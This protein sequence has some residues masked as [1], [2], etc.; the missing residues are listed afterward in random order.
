MRPIAL[1]CGAVALALAAGQAWAQDACKNR[2]ELDELSD[3]TEQKALI[4]DVL[5]GA[6]VVG[7]AVTVVLILID[8]DGERAPSYGSVEIGPG[9]L[10]GTF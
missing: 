6:S 9:S 2:G 3:S 4:T 8:D 1:T 5:L 7:A 10:R